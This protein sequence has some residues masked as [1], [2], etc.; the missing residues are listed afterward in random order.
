MR[1]EGPGRKVKPPSGPSLFVIHPR[2][3]DAIV[4]LLTHQ[5]HLET[6]HI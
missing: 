6:L 5:E 1:S 2:S 4:L 3:G